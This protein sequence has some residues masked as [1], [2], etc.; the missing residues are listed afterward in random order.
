[1]IILFVLTTPK[2]GVSFLDNFTKFLGKRTS[3]VIDLT[4]ALGYFNIFSDVYILILPISG[5]ISLN[6]PARRKIGV[7]FIFM[8]GLLAVVASTV[9]LYYRYQ[10][11]YT[12][13]TTWHLMP[14]AFLTILEH[15]IGVDCSCMPACSVAIR[16]ELP[17]LTKLKSKLTS[18]LRSWGAS[19]T[20]SK[21][22]QSRRFFSLSERNG[23]GNKQDPKFDANSG[24][25]IFLGTLPKLPKRM[26]QMR[27]AREIFWERKN[28]TDTGADE[29][30]NDISSSSTSDAAQQV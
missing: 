24:N 21:S 1:M 26:H 22:S 5:V 14:N 11:N 15:T 20:F 29:A 8:T 4:L 19:L 10:T 13:N 27:T 3:P 30:G 28:C 16:R 9:S 25:G 12:G 17:M 18:R 7:I 23:S 6:L 2:P